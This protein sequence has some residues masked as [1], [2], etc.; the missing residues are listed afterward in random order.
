MSSFGQV[1]LAASSYPV[2]SN[3]QQSLLLFICSS[4]LLD[5][6]QIHI[7]N[8][9]L[10]WQS[11]SPKMASKT[12]NGTSSEPV[13]ITGASGFV[14]A[15]V[16]NE[17]L[18]H[19]YSVRGTVRSEESANNVR[20]THAKYGDKLSFT[21]VKDVAAPGAF[22]EAV[23]GV[24]GVCSSHTSPYPRYHSTHVNPFP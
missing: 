22:D 11:Y 20:K 6:S 9:L 10:Q 13:L 17:F 19:G 12:T 15:H 23:K 21:I 16:L 7:S 18:E 8:T 4:L 24:Q 1:L 3:F 5:H 14:A 2:L